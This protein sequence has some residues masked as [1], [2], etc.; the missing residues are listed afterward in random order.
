[1]KKRKDFGRIIARTMA[2]LSAALVLS[3]SIPYVALA[4]KESEIQASIQEKKKQ[5]QEEEKKKAE[6][7]AN[8][9]N[10]QN[11]K[12]QLEK[13]K[14]DLSAYVS[15]LDH[16][17]TEIMDKIEQLNL[18]IES[19]TLEIN[20]TKKELEEAEDVRD[21][22]YAAMK[23]RVQILYEQGDDYYLELLITTHGFG[24]FLNNMENINKL[25]DY[26]NKMYKQYKETVSYVETVKE[27]LEAEEAV[28]EEDKAAAEEEQKAIEE[29]IE[30][31]KQQIAAYQ[32][33]IN[34]KSA[35]IAEFEHDL[36]AENAVISQL[37]KAVAAEQSKLVQQ[38]VYDGGA[39]CWPAPSYTRVSSEYGYRI[40]P[41]LGTNKFH[42]GV[43]LAAPG[44][45][46]ILAAY[47]GVVVGAAYNDSMGNYVMIDH[48]GGLYTIYMHASKL[49]VSSGQSVSRGQKIALVGTTGR[50]TGNHLHFSVRVNGNYVSPWNY[51]VKP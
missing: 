5:I 31:K 13:N 24:D 10:V 41:I 30:A 40:H 38:R 21:T 12:K 45:S 20:E 49:L 32:A 16:N 22:Q 28:L 2:A 17:V 27:K 39:F 33:D 23:K 6:I 35:T 44:G 46:D 47:D 1:M 42:N 50:S 36:A 34:S 11:I 51:I 26:D 3:T 48:G 7:K 4:D 18:D 15:E 19:K 37:E 29:L 25:A 9:T 14:A 43:D 8:I